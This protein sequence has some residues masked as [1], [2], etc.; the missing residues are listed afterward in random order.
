MKQL[1]YCICL[2]RKSGYSLF[3]LQTRRGP[4]KY[5]AEVF[6]ERENVCYGESGSSKIG[7]DGLQIALYSHLLISPETPD[8]AKAV[9]RLSRNHCA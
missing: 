6:H 2:F 9:I 7:S 1:L 5:I 3:F 8:S 4:Y